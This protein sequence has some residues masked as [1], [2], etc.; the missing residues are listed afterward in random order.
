MAALVG[1]LFFAAPAALA[2]PFATPLPIPPVL[3]AA[4]IE[5]PVVESDVQILPGAKT[6]MWTYGGSFPGPT[7]RRPAGQETRVTFVNQLS[8]AADALTVHNHGAHVASAED[9]QPQEIAGQGL[10]IGPGGKRTYVYPLT[11]AGAPERAAFQ[12]YHDH[13]LDV[14]GRNVWNGLAGMFIVDDAVDAALPLPK[15]DYDVPLMIADRSF[16]ATNQLTYPEPVPFGSEGRTFP[17]T[18]LPPNDELSGTQMLVNG[19]PQPYFAV[20][21]RRYRL[22]LLNASNAR[23]LTLSLANGAAMDQIATESGLLPAPVERTA[24]TLGPAERAEVVVDFAGLL[25]QQ[26]VLTSS[27]GDLMRFDVTSAASDDSSVPTSLRAVPELGHA[28]RERSF[29][30][31]LVEDTDRGRVSW[32]ING[33]TY[34]PFRTDAAPQLGST[35]TWTLR[36]GSGTH[37]V[38]IHGTDF[39]VMSRNGQAPPPWEAGLK[40]TILIAPKEIVVIKLRFTDHLGAFVFHC[41][42]LEHEDNGMM[43][44]FVVG[45]DEPE[46]PP[47]QPP[48]ANETQTPLDAT[49]APPAVA[50]RADLGLRWLRPARLLRS[51][52]SARLRLRVVAR[53]GAPAPAARIAVSLP[54]GLTA[55]NARRGRLVLRVGALAAG[56]SRTIPIRVRVGTSPRAGHISARRLGSADGDARND[57][58]VLAYRRVRGGLRLQRAGAASVL[59]RLAR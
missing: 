37:V 33:H 1:G 23:V 18:G 44:R 53:G 24:L 50:A 54:R 14:T 10:L 56:T 9:G 17:G 4:D 15:G 38:H 6:R 40:E 5:I 12:W 52:H 31:G 49:V 20:A 45:G 8:D 16:D 22:R 55:R 42:V 41:H 34:N 39:R 25:G 26:V 13:R 19:A 36:G 58:A 30:L 32:G 43:A 47:V 7:I 29:N 2:A 21:A 3:T 35:E 46:Q 51:R 48:P 11:E 59:C 57:R 27:A 28:T